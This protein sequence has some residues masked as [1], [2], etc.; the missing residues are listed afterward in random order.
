MSRSATT[1]SV[2]TALLSLI[3]SR[4][5]IDRHCWSSSDRR[6]RRCR[7][8]TISALRLVRA[9]RGRAARRPVQPTTTRVA[10]G[11]VTQVV[12]LARRTL[13]V[14]SATARDRGRA[15][16]TN[17]VR[18]GTFVHRR[19]RGLHAWSHAGRCAA[20]RGP[21]QECRHSSRLPRPRSAH[22]IRVAS[23]SSTTDTS[24]VGRRPAGASRGPPYAH[25]RRPGPWG[26]LARGVLAHRIIR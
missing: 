16:V 21:R 23:L 18:S 11:L 19:A 6:I 24:A 26:A 12:A 10:R 3:R 1:S 5:A 9:G 4:R 17:H 2:R 15:A 8:R 13:A 14:R 20:S 22:A 25:H 7:R